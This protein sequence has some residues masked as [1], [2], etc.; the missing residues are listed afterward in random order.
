MKLRNL[1]AA[2]L[3]LLV[4]ATASH[5]AIVYTVNRTIGAGSVVGSVTTD[6]TLGV[7]SAAN[8]TDWSLTIDEGDAEGSFLL[9]AVNSDLLV[10]GDGLTASLTHLLFD[11]SGA[12]D[13]ALWQNPT[14]GSL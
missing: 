3:F 9:T 2:M 1:F 7:L 11:F 4:A 12:G 10:D 13:L 5:A 6:G 8:V 14:T